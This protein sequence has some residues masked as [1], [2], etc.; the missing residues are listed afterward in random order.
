MTDLRS[1]GTARDV[2]VAGADD[3]TALDRMLREHS[4]EAIGHKR[5]TH[6]QSARRD[7]LTRSRVEKSIA[8][9]DGEGRIACKDEINDTVALNK[10]DDRMKQHS[11]EAA[12]PYF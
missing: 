12:F 9:F 7:Q 10:S 6:Q 1:D 3:V 5:K 2:E 4:R 11:R 8:A